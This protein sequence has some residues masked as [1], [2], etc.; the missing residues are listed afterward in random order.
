MWGHN[1]SEKPGSNV[2]DPFPRLN[3]NLRIL[4]GDVQN[5]FPR[6]FLTKIFSLLSPLHLYL[7]NQSST[8]GGCIV[9]T[10]AAVPR[11][12]VEWSQDPFPHPSW[13]LLNDPPAQDVPLCKGLKFH[14][15]FKFSGHRTLRV[16]FFLIKRKF[17]FYFACNWYLC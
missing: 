1:S 7:G 9:M 17:L 13:H 8:E 10:R 11:S 5:N 12:A 15:S 16:V 2:L 3:P 14:A 6:P 4:F